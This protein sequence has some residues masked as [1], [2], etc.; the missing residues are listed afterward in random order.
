MVKINHASIANI[1]TKAISN[2]DISRADTFRKSIA[3]IRLVGNA[4]V[5]NVRH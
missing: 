3:G 4:C 1:F 5:A 2:W